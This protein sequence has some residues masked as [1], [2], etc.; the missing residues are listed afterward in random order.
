MVVLGLL[1]VCSRS[2]CV[3]LHR[4][5]VASGLF[6]CVPNHFRLNWV[7]SWSFWVYFWL[8]LGQFALVCVG[9]WSFWFDLGQ[10]TVG[11]GWVGSIHGRLGLLSVCSDLLMVFLSH[12]LVVLDWIGTVHC[13]FM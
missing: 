4:F 3:V 5:M 2:F 6:E 11:L 7:S 10:F 9:S 8:D 1:L 13:Y 12:L